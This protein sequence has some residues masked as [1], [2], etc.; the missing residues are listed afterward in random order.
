MDAVKRAGGQDQDE[1]VRFVV[2]QMGGDRALRTRRMFGGH[3]LYR[4]GLMFAI[5]IRDR[6]YFKTDDVN[7]CSFEERGLL[8]FSYES[9]GK[10][11][12]IRY[13]EAP[14][15]VFDDSEEM[16]AWAA[17]AFAAALRAR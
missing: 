5:I 11:V 1:F 4:D 13:Y 15:D 17:A 12:T 6:L 9:R 14:A 10:T 3:G 2:G 8:P 7:R 16:Q